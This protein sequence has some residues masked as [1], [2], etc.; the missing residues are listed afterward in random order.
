MHV[1]TARCM[2]RGARYSPT[3]MSP[4]LEQARTPARERAGEGRDSVAA[5]AS[6]SSNVWWLRERV[7]SYNKCPPARLP[8]SVAVGG[9]CCSR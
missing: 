8:G 2:R 1:G 5:A 6:S 4:L 9:C 3:Y 7:H